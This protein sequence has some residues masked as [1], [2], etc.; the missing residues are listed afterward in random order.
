MSLRICGI[1]LVVLLSVVTLPC[2]ISADEAKKDKDAGRSLF[3]GK[4]LKGW[5]ASDFYGNGKLS[6]KDG[7]IVIE[8]GKKMSG[9]TYSGKDFPT[10]NYEVSL[11]AKKIDGNDFFATTTFPV[12][13]T[14]CSLVVGGWGGEVVGLSSIDSSDASMNDTRKDIEFKKNQWYKIRIRVT[15][16]KIE[17]WIDGKKVVDLDHTDHRLSI[18]IECNASKPF[19]IATYNTVGAVRN[20]RVQTLSKSTSEK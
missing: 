15:D 12:D 2:P 16:K 14:F 10:I 7:A 6:V 19:G 11:E 8:K 9:I 4:T 20:I 1:A 18:R 13:K 17:S 5:I 3:D